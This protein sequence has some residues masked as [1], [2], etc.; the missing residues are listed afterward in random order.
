MLPD[1]T[2]DR[3]DTAKRTLM[4]HDTAIN[5]ALRNFGTSIFTEMTLASNEAGALNLAQ[6]FPDFDGPEE[7]FDMARTAMAEHHNQYARSMGH[8]LLIDAVARHLER[9]QALA[10]DPG[11][12]ICITNGCTEALSASVLGLLEPGE[13]VILFEPFYDSYPAVAAMAGCTVKSLAL[14][15]PDF[16]LDLDALADLIGPNTRAIILNSPHNPSGKV[17][18]LDELQG[19]ATLCCEHDLL[20]FADEVYEALTFEDAKHISIATLSGM[21]E[22][23]LVLSSTG[24]TLSLTGWKIGWAAGPAH[25][26]AGTAAAKQFVSFSTC[27]PFQ[28]AMAQALDRYQDDYLQE[29]RRGYEER[30][31]VLVDIL[32]EAGFGTSIPKGAY[33]ILADISGLTDEDSRSYAFRLIREK[34]VAS[35]PTSSFYLSAPDEGRKLL[36]FAFCKRVE[37]LELARAQLCS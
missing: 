19:I 5:A 35:V 32:V 29:F 34:G 28:V 1:P 33:F 36:R 12:E 17:F 27:T 16:A 21:R 15:F 24:K 22:R 9:S 30:R 18:S 25:L 6:G 8:P 10:Y 14:R 20:V 4:S 26:I 37:T 2:R 23:T 7:I 11:S 3:L 31:N 13:E